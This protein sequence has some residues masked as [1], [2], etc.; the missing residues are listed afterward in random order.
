MNGC[1][2]RS[3]IPGMEREAHDERDLLPQA[4]RRSEHETSNAPAAR[5][6]EHESDPAA[7]RMADDIDLR[8]PEGLHPTRDELGIPRQLVP[9]VGSIR[10]AVPGKVQHKD[11]A[12]PSELW[13]YLPPREV[14][15]N[16][17]MKQDRGWQSTRATVFRPVQLHT[18]DDLEERARLTDWRR[19]LDRCLRRHGGSRLPPIVPAPLFSFLRSLPAQASQSLPEQWQQTTAAWGARASRCYRRRRIAAF[20]SS[21]R[22]V[23][24]SVK[25]SSTLSRSWTA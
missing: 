22:N 18:I 4:A 12:V 10:E 15:V 1:P 25:K 11:P 21:T 9:G 14:R 5:A 24:D 8:E 20:S 3:T 7:E 19:C 2:R 23:N 13:R 6:Q 16:E 17:A